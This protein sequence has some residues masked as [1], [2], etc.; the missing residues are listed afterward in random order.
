MFKMAHIS[1][2]LNSAFIIYHQH[3][4]F[5]DLTIG[6]NK[7]TEFKKK[8]KTEGSRK[9]KLIEVIILRK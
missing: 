4:A 3:Q 9:H 6:Q 7:D 5:I 8:K 2:H 1:R